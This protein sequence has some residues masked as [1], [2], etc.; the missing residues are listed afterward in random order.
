MKRAGARLDSN[1]LYRWSFWLLTTGA[2]KWFPQTHHPKELI[3]AQYGEYIR[4]DKV[5]TV[6]RI[7]EVYCGNC[8]EFLRSSVL[9]V[10][11]FSV[12][13]CKTISLTVV[14]YIQ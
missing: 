2:N 12:T 14:D 5:F 3:P 10:A 7:G 13:L 1:F 6:G 8:R 4:E 11:S 9:P